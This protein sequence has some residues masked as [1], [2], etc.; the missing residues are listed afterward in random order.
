MNPIRPAHALALV[1]LTFAA[2][3]A[4]AGTGNLYSVTSKMEIVGMPFSMPPRTAEVC[5][6][7]DTASE[8]MVPHDEN[9]RVEDFRV[10][11]NKSTSLLY[12][13]L[14]DSSVC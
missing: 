3:A 6:P 9:C 14:T 11:G 1:L 4:Q 2:G 5:G 10:V 7:K 13:A 12:R 8:K